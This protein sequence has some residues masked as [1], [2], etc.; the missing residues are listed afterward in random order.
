VE[1][2]FKWNGI[3]YAMLV[4]IY[5]QSVEGEKRYSPAECIGAEKHWV[6]GQPVEADNFC[7]V[8]QTLTK[9]NRGIHTTPAMVAGPD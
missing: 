3:D 8:H 5:G 1:K 9:A 6:M 4:K 7:R 2:A